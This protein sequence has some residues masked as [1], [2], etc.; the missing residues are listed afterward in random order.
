[1]LHLLMSSLS[2]SLDLCIITAADTVT[3]YTILHL[4]A[5]L[6][7]SSSFFNKKLQCL[8]NAANIITARRKTK[9]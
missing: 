5:L 9:R 3:H 1:M 8:F 4:S 2:L 7:D 6:R